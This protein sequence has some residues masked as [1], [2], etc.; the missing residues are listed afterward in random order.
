MR[1]T[2]LLKL[3][4]D[5]VNQSHLRAYLKKPG[6]TRPLLRAPGFEVTTLA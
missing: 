3:C 1:D 2:Q 6:P 4:L 5:V